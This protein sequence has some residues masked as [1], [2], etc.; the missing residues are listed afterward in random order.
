MDLYKTGRDTPHSIKH[1]VDSMSFF[2]KLFDIST[3][4]AGTVGK[5]TAGA[6][7]A[8]ATAG[9][10]GS[11]NSSSMSNS[12][13]SSSFLNNLG[14]QII[15]SGVQFGFNYLASQLSNKQA[16]EN[17][18]YWANYNS[19]VNQMQRL[20]EA[21]LNPNL[22]YDNGANAQF[23][24][25]T[26]APKIDGIKTNYLSALEVANL[27]ADL[28]QKQAN[29]NASQAN[30]D[31]LSSQKEGQDLDNTRKKSADPEYMGELD[32]KTLNN[33]LKLIIA[34]E[35][36][37][38]YL[39]DIR[40]NENRVKKIY[41][42]WYEEAGFAFENHKDSSL[43]LENSILAAEANNADSLVREKLRCSQA[44][45]DYIVGQVAMLDEMKRQLELQNKK[46]EAE[47]DLVKKQQ[48][49]EEWKAAHE[50]YLAEEQSYIADLRSYG[51]NPNGSDYVQVAGF[52]LSGI[53]NA[54]NQ[55]RRTGYNR[56]R[57][58]GDQIL[59]G[60]Y[61]QGK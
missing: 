24:G 21:G 27:K 50:K 42:D 4:V 19:P 48:M 7:S 54:T 20:R 47:T 23:A 35:K 61:N 36:G 52:V 46:I 34:K 44:Q 45:A 17:A 12:N 41:A 56:E 29:A 58:R 5:V 60:L 10:F 14:S 31:L 49:T 51:I 16:Q 37:E 43:I 18:K 1:N 9:L 57:Y 8:G 11:Q 55:Y 25:N 32:A 3:G 30:A 59:D 39:N 28:A 38:R 53:R 15:G 26:D 33:N 6:T 13:S 22:V 40:R 2:S